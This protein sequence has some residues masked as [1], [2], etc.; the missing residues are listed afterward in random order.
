MSVLDRRRFISARVSKPPIVL[1]T[2][3]AGNNN[4]SSLNLTLPAGVGAGDLLIALIVSRQPSNS[5]T[6]TPPSG[7]STLYNVVGSSELRR[8]AA[9]YLIASGSLSSATFTFS[10]GQRAA[11][12]AYRIGG[13]TGVPES[14]NVA[15]GL[16][17][18]NVVP[19]WGSQSASLW[20]AS[21]GFQIRSFTAPSG[22]TD[23]VD[24]DDTA[25]TIRIASARRQLKAANLDPD[26]F[27]LG[28]SSAYSAA[29]TIAVRGIP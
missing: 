4:T 8:W 21:A 10:R 9:F 23:S 27:T 5:A 2:S 11:A 20:L 12:I 7:W 26:P 28:S 25:A 19:S 22:F 29:S 3:G 17:P 24:Q 6:I 13:F 1:G 16:N 15:S 18:P 14:G